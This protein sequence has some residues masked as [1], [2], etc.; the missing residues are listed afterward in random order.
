M[1]CSESL[2]SKREKMGL[3]V[4]FCAATSRVPVQ[5]KDLFGS[6]AQSFQSVLA[7]CVF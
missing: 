6:E 5:E 4:R 1:S 7:R 3:Q 2:A